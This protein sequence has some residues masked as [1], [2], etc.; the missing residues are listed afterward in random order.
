VPFVTTRVAY[1]SKVQK[2]KEEIFLF[3]LAAKRKVLTFATPNRTN[4][5]GKTASRGS[6][7]KG[8]SAPEKPEKKVW[9]LRKKRLP[10]ASPSKGKEKRAAG[11]FKALKSETHQDNRRWEASKKKKKISF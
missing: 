7:Q 2:E 1:K 11:S 8:S 6:E 10:L 9:L 5:S 3:P 4:G